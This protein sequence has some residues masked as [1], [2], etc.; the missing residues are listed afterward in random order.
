MRYAAGRISGPWPALLLTGLLLLSGAARAQPI[1]VLNDREPMLDLREASVM[2]ID[3]QG[4][5]TVEELVSEKARVPMLPS[6]ASTT[7]SLGEQAALWQH[8]RFR[9]SSGSHQ[10]WILEFPL[11]LLDKVT[12][13]QTDPGGA[14]S[15]ESAGDTVPITSWPEAGRYAQFHL[16]LPGNGLHDV[17]VRIQHVTDVSIPI[18]AVTAPLQAQRLQLQYLAMGL[19]FGALILL[20]VACAVQS[21]IYR[22]KAYAWYAVYSALMMMVVASWTGVAG[23]LLWG[24]FSDWNNMAQG[25][26]GILGGSAALLVVRHLCGTTSRQPWFEGGVYWAALAGM[27]LALLYIVLGRGQGVRMI[28]AYLALVVTLG[29]AKSFLAWRRNDLVGLWVLASF[30]PVAAATLLTVA[31][32]LGRVPSSGFSQYALLMALSLQVPLLLGAL[33]IRS[34][35][36]HSIELREQEMS[37]QDALTGLLAAPIFLDRL[38]QVAER[39][40]RHHEPAAVMYIELVNYAYIRKTWGIAVAEQSLL[41]SVIKLRRI[42]R[43]VN[44]VGRVD[45][46]RFGLILEG[47]ASRTVVTELAAR[48]IAAGLMPL[49]GL[50]PEVILQFHV[51]GVLLTE[52]LAP[53]PELAAQLGSI[54]TS[55]AARTR[56]PIRFLEPE[57][58]RPMPLEGLPGEDS[59]FGDTEIGPSHFPP[60]QGQPAS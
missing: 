58:T 39:A 35:E 27:P 55:M 28:S 59:G 4:Q 41:R 11:P 48:L 47:V 30:T 20:I 18:H 6:S 42:L 10:D 45:E 7:Y 33:N 44:T 53:G 1:T 25:C 15:A 14:W 2:W 50:K 36:R 52:K 5:T 31:V 16:R 19:V 8:Y 13:Y 56:R 21:W 22:D 9:K 12:V 26:L 32:I 51:A 24:G 3:T 49:K 54:L 57:L 38:K 23:H 34:R 60:Q 17:Y 29:L 40:Q 37:S 46:A 43:D